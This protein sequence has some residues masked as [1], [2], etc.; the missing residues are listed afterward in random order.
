MEILYRLREVEERKLHLQ[1]CYSDIY[2][3]TQDALGY[4]S[5]AA[6]RRV[7]AMPSVS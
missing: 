4:S 3:F 5:S 7:P 6:Y 2:R 1:I